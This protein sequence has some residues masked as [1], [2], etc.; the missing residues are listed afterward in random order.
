MTKEEIIEKGSFKQSAS[1]PSYSYFEIELYLPFFEK[2][3]KISAT[4]LPS[5]EAKPEMNLI[6]AIINEL[7]NYP[8][9]NREWLKR[10][11]WN[12]Y[13]T[14]ISS[15]SYGMVAYE[16]FKSE[17]E[18]NQAYFK[19]YNPEDAYNSAE[20]EFIL[21]DVS[22]LDFRY[23]NLHY[24]CPWESEHGIR[25]GVMNGQFDSIE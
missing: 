16:G 12:H 1:T 10:E 3:V 4:N 2:I 18:A 8:L 21:F 24:K 19:I 20:L 23:F 11:I 17:K 7:L 5:L 25:I 9:S 6:T 22:F 14:I 15:A 13:D